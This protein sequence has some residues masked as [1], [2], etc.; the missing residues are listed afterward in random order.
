MQIYGTNRYGGESNSDIVIHAS[1]EGFNELSMFCDAVLKIYEFR[2]RG[3]KS[4]CDNVVKI[5]KELQRMMQPLNTD[6][7]RLFLTSKKAEE[8]KIFLNELRDT[9]TCDQTKYDI[10]DFL[11]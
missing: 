5:A 9:T 7:K 10:D 6:P 1:G 3:E 11:H 4:T 8:A 2:D